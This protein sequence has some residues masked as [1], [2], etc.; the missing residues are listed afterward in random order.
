[1]PVADVQRKACLVRLPEPLLTTITTVPSTWAI[2]TAKGTWRLLAPVG[3]DTWR[4]AA[5]GADFRLLLPP[6]GRVN[7]N[8]RGRF[9]FIL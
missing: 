1:M 7:R 4:N 8:F 2:M 3:F 9:A 5:P 6:R